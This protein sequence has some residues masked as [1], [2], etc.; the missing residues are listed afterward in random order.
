[1]YRVII[2]SLLLFVTSCGPVY[3]TTHHFKPPETEKG[4][5]CANQC[6]FKKQECYHDCQNLRVQCEQNSNIA[7]LAGQVIDA[8]DKTPDGEK[9]KSSY[10]NSHRNK[11]INA[12]KDCFGRCDSMHQLCHQNCGGIVETETKCVRNCDKIK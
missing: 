5:E 1:M 7:N 3:K 11:C 2:L 8:L 12:E 9:K 4:R 6:L 10:A